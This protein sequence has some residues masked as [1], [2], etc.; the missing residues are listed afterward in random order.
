MLSETN[1]TE[2][3]LSLCWR[4]DTSEYLDH[5]ICKQIY[6]LKIIDDISL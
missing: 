3:K 2:C 5:E 6:G 1:L 4:V